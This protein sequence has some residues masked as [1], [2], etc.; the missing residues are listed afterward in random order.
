MEASQE[1]QGSDQ[2]QTGQDAQPEQAQDSQQEPQDDSQLQTPQGDQPIPTE[3]EPTQDTSDAQP[4]EQ[5]PGAVDQDA[6]QAQREADRE[7]AQ[8]A[9]NERS[10]GGEINDGE[11][12]EARDL[13]N[14]RAATDPAAGVPRPTESEVQA[15]GAQ[16]QS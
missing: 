5:A 3:D 7:A 15:E 4:V 14:E 10:G 1:N 16:D 9:H 8:R 2:E 11:I 13:H 6:R 12:S